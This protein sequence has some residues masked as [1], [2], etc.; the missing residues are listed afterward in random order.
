MADQGQ[1]PPDQQIL[2]QPQPL[3]VR[4]ARTPAQYTI[5]QPMD[6]SQRSDIT[7][8]TNGCAALEGDKYNGTI[9]KL[10]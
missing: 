2:A 5:V 7:V 4:V 8:F 10:F 9:L 1:H 3:P 6:F